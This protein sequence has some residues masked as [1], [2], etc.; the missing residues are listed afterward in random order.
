MTDNPKGYRHP[1]LLVTAHALDRLLREASPAATLIDLRPAEQFAAGHLP[2]AVHLDLFG[3]SLTDT[4]PAPLKSF[5]WIIEHLL[6]ERG[7][8]ADRP[9]VVYDDVSGIR[10][11]R[12]FWFLEYFGH[13]DVR[14]IDGGFA[15]WLDAKLP[16][17]RD[18]TVPKP[19]QWH[20]TPAERRAASRHDVAQRIGSPA[21]VMLEDLASVDLDLAALAQ[22]YTRRAGAGT[23]IDLTVVTTA[24]RFFSWTS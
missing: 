21:A 9:V 7:V 6:A 15:A 3:L 22:G 1:E 11:A 17:T 12:A 2:S 24:P 19:V 23:P 8:S 18:A 10:A 20:A 14:V 5:L 4:D 16:V 13:P